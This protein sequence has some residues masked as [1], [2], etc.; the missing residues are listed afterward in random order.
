MVTLDAFRRQAFRGSF[1]EG[2]DVLMECADVD[3]IRLQPSWGFE[4]REN[5]QRRLSAKDLSGTIARINP[6][7]RKIRIK[8]DYDLFIFCCPVSLDAMYVNAVEG[9]QDRCKI[10]V[11]WINELWANRVPDYKNWLPSL[12]RFDHLFLGLSGSVDPVSQVT[13][14]IC[15]FVPAGVDALRF[16]PYPTPVIRAVDVYSIGRR[17][18]GVHEALLKLAANKGRF[19]I[20]DTLQYGDSSAPDFRQHREL[21]ANIAKRSKFFVV[22]PAKVDLKE[23]TRGQIEVA[24]RYFEGAAAGTVMI[25]QAPNCESFRQLFDWADAV[26]E[27]HSDGSNVDQVISELAADP[28]KL[29]Q[30]SRKNSS[31]ALRRHDWVYRWEEILSVAGIEL[32]HSM[33]SRKRRLHDLA[34][35]TLASAQCA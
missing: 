34:E 26:V 31:E 30:M 6:G 7:L 16:S 4:T 3:V 5:W 14:R 10:S 18:P 1:S 33:Q 2:Q 23:H 11:C 27:I 8:K 24:T 35:M 28:V 32:T 9:W 29:S 15:H 21:Y 19:Y 20:H 13:R 17:S 12:N 25:G 22:A